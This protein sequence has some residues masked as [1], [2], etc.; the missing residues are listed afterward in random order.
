MRVSRAALIDL[1]D[2]HENVTAGAIAL[3]YY[4]GR[5]NP[6][7]AGCSGDANLGARSV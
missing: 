5:I 7:V 4:H 6:M 2:V 3:N 1:G